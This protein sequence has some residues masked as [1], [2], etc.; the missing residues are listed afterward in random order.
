MRAGHRLRD[1]V[2]LIVDADVVVMFHRPQ[3]LMYVIN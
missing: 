3:G 1:I 2:S